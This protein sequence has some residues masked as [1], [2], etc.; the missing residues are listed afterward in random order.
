[1]HS[2]RDL[3]HLPLTSTRIVTQDVWL[4]ITLDK[5]GGLNLWRTDD[6]VFFPERKQ[7]YSISWIDQSATDRPNIHLT[8]I[9]DANAPL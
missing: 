1:M 2:H 9:Q 6:K 5:L 8:R 4:S 7:W 3:G